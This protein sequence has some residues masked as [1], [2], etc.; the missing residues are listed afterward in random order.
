MQHLCLGA[1][2]FAVWPDQ[3]QQ[4]SYFPNKVLQTGT[5]LVS[6]GGCFECNFCSQWIGKPGFSKGRIYSSSPQTQW[7]I[8]V[9]EHHGPGKEE[10]GR[11]CLPES[12]GPVATGTASHR[13]AVHRLVSVTLNFWESCVCWLQ[14]FRS[15]HKTCIYTI[16]LVVFVDSSTQEKHWKTWMWFRL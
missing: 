10:A 7:L 4:M 16:W 2:G 1:T 8:A 11:D 15:F 9:W 6:L 13:R 5:P 14:H 12:V 3:A